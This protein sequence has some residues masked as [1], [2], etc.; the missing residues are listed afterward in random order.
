MLR[1]VVLA[2]LAARLAH[3]AVTLPTLLA[4]HM[5]IQR[6]LPVHV[7]GKADPGGPESVADFS[8]VGYHFGRFLQERLDVPIGL[9]QIAWGGTPIDS[10]TGYS[11]ITADAALMPALAE[12]AK[13]MRNHPAAPFG[14][15]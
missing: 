11:S 2:C 7:W 4:D 13:I 6:G 15:E 1:A 12:W 10:W 9:I 14:S 3:A 5:V 8:A